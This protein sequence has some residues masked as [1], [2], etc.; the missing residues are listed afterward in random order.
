MVEDILIPIDNLML[1]SVTI[2]IC[3]MY[4]WPHRNH[5]DNFPPAWRWVYFYVPQHFFNKTLK[6]SDNIKN[7]RFYNFFSLVLWVRQC[8]KPRRVN[9]IDESVNV[10]FKFVLIRRILFEI[11]CRQFYCRNPLTKSKKLFFRPAFI[12]LKKIKCLRY[13]GSKFNRGFIES[14]HLDHRFSCI[15]SSRSAY[16]STNC[17]TDKIHQKI[18]WSPRIKELKLYR[19]HTPA[20]IKNQSGA[21]R[22]MEIAA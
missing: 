18:H 8:F 7:M 10:S 19:F 17:T 9:T 4:A 3:G 1:F 22:R 20:Q 14:L 2:P 15:N 16:K 6:V 13:C 12:N 21:S 11:S 5:S